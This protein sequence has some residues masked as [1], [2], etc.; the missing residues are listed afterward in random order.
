MSDD[1]VDYCLL[2]DAASMIAQK[3]HLGLGGFGILT[4]TR[5]VTPVCPNRVGDFGRS[6]GNTLIADQFNNRVIEVDLHSR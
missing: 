6:P 4:I 3:A 5:G 2:C 1:I